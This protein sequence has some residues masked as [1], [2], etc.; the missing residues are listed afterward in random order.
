[1]PSLTSTLRRRAAS[2]VLGVLALQACQPSA[3]VTQTT[4]DGAAV[5]SLASSA[6]AALKEV[7]IVTGVVRAPRG[8]IGSVIPTGGSNVIPTGGSNVIPTRS[9]EHTSELQSR[10]PPPFPPPL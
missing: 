7:S 3:Q 5:A 9:E 1:M 4:G 10:P 2:L 6:P 8:I